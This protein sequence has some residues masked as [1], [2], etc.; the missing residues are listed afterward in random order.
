STTLFRSPV[1]RGRPA[2]FSFVTPG[3]L[4]DL[5]HRRP[6]ACRRRYAERLFDEAIGKS[7]KCLPLRT[8]DDED[9]AISVADGLDRFNVGCEREFRHAPRRARPEPHVQLYPRPG[10]TS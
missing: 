8:A 3:E 7:K 5:R 9:V 1:V 4:D 6:V 2:V 10:L